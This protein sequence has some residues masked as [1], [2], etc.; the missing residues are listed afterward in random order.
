MRFSSLFVTVAI[1]SLLILLVPASYAAESI[2]LRMQDDSAPS[3]KLF[4]L[5]PQEQRYKICLRYK[6][7][8]KK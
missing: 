7:L 1:F 6:K 5:F 3:P 8:V 2:N 4:M